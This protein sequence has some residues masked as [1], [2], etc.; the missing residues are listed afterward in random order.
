MSTAISVEHVTKQ[1]RLG[2]IGSN[3]L[4]GDVSRWWA[5]LRGRPDPSR[6][7]QEKHH[8]RLVGNEFWALNDV[9][10]DVKEGE[11]VGIVGP[12]GAGKSTLFKILSQ[13]TA[14]SSGRITLRGRV[15]SLLEVGTGFQPDLTGRENVFLNG[16]ILGMTKA[17]IR[18]N[19][20]AIVAFSECEKFID[21]P[22]KRYSSGMYV[23][24][25]FAVAAHLESEILI[26]DEVLAVGDAEFQKK[27]LGRMRCI[28]QQG[29]TVLFVSH[30]MSSVARLCSRAI[31][32]RDGQIALEGPVDQVTDAYLTTAHAGKP[33]QEWPDLAKAPGNDTVRLHAVRVHGSDNTGAAIDIRTS[34][35]LEVEYQVLT[36]GSTLVP[37]IHLFNT[38]G[39]CVFIAQ[40][41]DAEW[42]GKPR[43]EGRYRSVCQ[44]PGNFLAEGM[45][46]AGVAISS[47]VPAH[48]VHAWQ[49]DALAFQ[50]VDYG[51]GGTARGD[52]MGPMS[53]VVR[54]LLPWKTVS[55]ALPIPLHNAG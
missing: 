31:L 16:A 18:K 12:N 29:R 6:K 35:S 52:Y 9:S 25:A 48:V 54:P 41:C 26:V 28:G 49:A 11:V 14:P 19:F 20:D 50:I 44:I 53:G 22:V 30:S 15:A 46:T 37:N 4:Q 27:C 7:L 45:F 1:Y 42:L 32:L 47:H 33:F 39:V 40:D 34:I 38:E 55:D 36:G 2:A 51:A 24:L 5:R 17:E 8:P 10:F 21:T 3:T 13:V 43:P 23:R